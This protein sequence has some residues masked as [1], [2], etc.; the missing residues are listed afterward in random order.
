M[1]RLCHSELLELCVSRR[2]RQVLGETKEPQETNLLTPLN[3][4]LAALTFLWTYPKGAERKMAAEFYCSKTKIREIIRQTLEVLDKKTQH[5][6]EWPPSYKNRIASG[7]FKDTIGIVDAFPIVLK[8]RPQT[9]DLRRQF[10]YFRERR[11]AYKVQT[12]IGLDNKLLNVTDA[13]PYGANAD[14]TVFRSSEVFFKLNKSNKALDLREPDDGSEDEG[15]EKSDLEL[16]DEN[17][18]DKACEQSGRRK[19]RKCIRKAAADK[20]YRGLPY[21]YLPIFKPKDRKMNKKE[22]KWN[23]ALSSLR[24]TVENVHSRLKDFAMIGTKYRRK[25]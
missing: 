1:E 25:K 7:D 17:L 3:I 24:S 18:D 5:L 19:T 2:R 22:R 4:L 16:G 9:D 10:W 14:Q 6:R 21:L 15:E 8:N 23:R 11:W 13:Y 20:G 12:F